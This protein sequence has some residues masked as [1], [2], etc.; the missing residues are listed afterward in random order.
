M[1]IRQFPIPVLPHL[2]HSP[3]HDRL[4]TA[5]QLS[6]AVKYIFLGF[7]FLL[8]PRCRRHR[9]LCASCCAGDW[10]RLLGNFL[11]LLPSGYRS[12]TF[13]LLRAITLRLSY[14]SRLLGSL[15][16]CGICFR[17]SIHH[18]A[19]AAVPSRHSTPSAFQTPAVE[20]PVGPS[21]GALHSWWHIV[22]VLR[23]SDISLV[24]QHASCDYPE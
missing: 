5:L 13:E 14:H 2:P 11:L 16:P 15:V 17:A 20:D 24:T 7:A 4:Q 8:H 6:V 18:Q 12:T 21:I 1:R 22:P 3:G 10:L 19:F 9:R 23:C